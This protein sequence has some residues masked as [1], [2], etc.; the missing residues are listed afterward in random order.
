MFSLSS[1][2]E[3]ENQAQDPLISLNFLF[4]APQAMRVSKMR[5]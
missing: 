4:V 2:G 1:L 5:V 3:K